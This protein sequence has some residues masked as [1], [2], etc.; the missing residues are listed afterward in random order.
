MGLSRNKVDAGSARGGQLD[1]GQF[2]QL[3]TGSGFA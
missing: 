2:G 1:T 3:D